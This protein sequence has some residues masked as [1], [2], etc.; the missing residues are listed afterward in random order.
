MA[1]ITAD[2]VRCVNDEA[3]VPPELLTGESPAAVWD[4]AE[5]LGRWKA[6]GAAA[7]P[8][9]LTSASVRL[10]RMGRR[11]ERHDPAGDAVVIAD[12]LTAAMVLQAVALAVAVVADIVAAAWSD[13]EWPIAERIAR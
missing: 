10:Y 2:F 13:C 5:R 6:E 12:L 3:G 1:Y 8:N 9:P 4:S 7:Q 11:P